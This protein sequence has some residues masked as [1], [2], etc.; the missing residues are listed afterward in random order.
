MHGTDTKTFIRTKECVYWHSPTAK[1]EQNKIGISVFHPRQQ[2]FD[3][4]SQTCLPVGIDCLPAFF[5]LEQGIVGRAMP[6]LCH[7]TAVATPF[8]GV[9]GID[10]VQ[11]DSL[12]KTTALQYLFEFAK[13]NP[14]YLPVET[15][16][17]TAEP[18]ELLNRNIGVKL[19][20]KIS[21]I[22]HNLTQPILDKTV[23]TVFKAGKIFG[24]FAVSFVSKRA[25]FGASCHNLLSL[26]PDVFSKIGL[27]QDF[28]IRSKNGNR[29]A[30]AVHI[31]SKNVFAGLE[32]N[33]ILVQVGN[34]MPLC[35]ISDSRALPTSENESLESLVAPVFFDRDCESSLGIKSKL[36]E[37]KGFCFEEFG[38]ALSSIEFDGDIGNSHA[39]CWLSGNLTQNIQNDAVLERGVFLAG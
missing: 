26:M 7:S 20:C 37:L 6:N 2:G 29:K 32:D 17:F 9:V 30:L 18:L 21:N 34:K 22:S 14:E 38:I 11:D 10:F 28:S 19:E 31:N 36:N 39:T 25:E 27:M 16:A 3:G 4:D 24:G 13:R 23:F 35:G 33:I 5:A 15:L 12:V 8:R 1:L